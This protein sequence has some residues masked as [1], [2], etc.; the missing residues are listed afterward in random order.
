LRVW[1]TAGD[2]R[3]RQ[4]IEAE[5]LLAA[6]ANW[7]ALATYA[8]RFVPHGPGLLIDLG[9]TTCDIV[10]LL[11]G[12]PHPLGRTDSA[13]LA[14]GELVY[15]GVRR[16]PLCAIFG[17]TKAAEWFATTADA[18]VI[19]GDLPEEP[20]RTDSADGRP[21]TKT[22]AQARLARMEC[23]EGAAWSWNQTLAFAG[24]VRDLQVRRIAQSVSQ[25]TARLPGAVQG[26]VL[27]GA[28]EFL[29]P[30]VLHAASLDLP[31]RI[32]LAATLG[33]DLSTAACAHAI[34]ILAAEERCAR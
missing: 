9:S 34:A 8:G 33:R 12:R 3:A 27:A 24:Q 32:S 17:L 22:H 15:C 31:T 23:D 21:L 25:M 10:P 28:G 29:L 26:V 2:F 13:R 30:A 11:D 5:P 6:A 1:T 14:A 18:Y 7:L 16:T 4:Q 19:L 20:D